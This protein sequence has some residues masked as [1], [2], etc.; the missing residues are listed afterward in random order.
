MAPLKI[1]I[2][3]SC[4]PHRV[5]FVLSL[6]IYM[7]FGNSIIKLREHDSIGKLNEKRAN[8]KRKNNQIQ[9]AGEFAQLVTLIY[10]FQIAL[11]EKNII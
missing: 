3:L 6:R 2:H 1:T 10:P 4:P 5:G 7:K 9:I 11:L 8:R